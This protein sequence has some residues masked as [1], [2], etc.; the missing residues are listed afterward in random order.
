MLWMLA[1]PAVHAA[2]MACPATLPV[3]Q[4]VAQKADGWTSFDEA[5]DD[6]HKF[7]FAEFSDGPPQQWARLVPTAS[8]AAQRDR[9]LVYEFGPRQQPWLVCSYEQTSVTLSQPLPP[10]TRLCRVTLDSEQDFQTVKRIEC[11]P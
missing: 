2:E 10:E 6:P 3:Q 9:V 7:Y 4:Q 11:E 8:A 5:G 1:A